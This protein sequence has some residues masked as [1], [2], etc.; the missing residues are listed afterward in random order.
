MDTFYLAK[1]IAGDRKKEID[2]DLR[3]HHMRKEENWGIFKVSKT[4]RLVMRFAPAVIVISILA[5]LVLI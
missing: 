1:T 2:D 3:I 4:R 5:M